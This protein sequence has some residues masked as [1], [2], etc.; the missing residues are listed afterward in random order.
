MQ[1]IIVPRIVAFIAF[2]RKYGWVL[3]VLSLLL[4]VVYFTA[5]SVIGSLQE[6]LP[7]HVR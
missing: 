3:F 6:D 7:M 5:G 4:A 2:M 1:N